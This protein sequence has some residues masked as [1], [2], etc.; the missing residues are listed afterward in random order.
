[1]DADVLMVTYNR[2]EYTRRSL[3]RLL[4]TADE[5]TRV[6]IWHNGDDRETLEVVRSFS[7][8]PRVHR[9][10]HSTENVKLHPPTN[11]LFTE[12]EGTYVSKVDD[13]CLMPDGWIET[14][15]RAHEDEARF[16]VLGCWRFQDEDF[17]PRLAARK[18]R[19]HAGGHRVLVNCWI[20]G[21]GYLMKRAC[22]DAEGVLRDGESFTEY[23]IR[24]A[25]A[26]WINGWYYPFLRQDHMDDPRSPNSLLKT[27][28]DFIRFGP[29]SAVQFGAGTLNG[30]TD[31]LRRDALYVQRASVNPR[32]LVGWRGRLGGL[33]ER[34]RLR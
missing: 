22:I 31:A 27:Q 21:S 8:H 13:D 24:L 17:R 6:W 15:R 23:C 28:G 4:E 18:I 11:W 33:I 25:L 5:R 26:G 12:A 30:W 1:V 10:H 16:G 34:L 20:E 29:L 9:V 32:S 14:L 3:G 19:E 2:P 7:N